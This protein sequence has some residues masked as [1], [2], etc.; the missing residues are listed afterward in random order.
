MNI[1]SQMEYIFVH[2]Y[3]Y[4]SITYIIYLFTCIK[5]Y[6]STVIIEINIELD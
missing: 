6:F 2:K 4:I 5:Q 3:Y 1:S